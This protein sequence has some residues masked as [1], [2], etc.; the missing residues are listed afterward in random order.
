MSAVFLPHSFA[1]RGHLCGLVAFVLSVPVNLCQAENSPLY[2]KDRQ[3][4]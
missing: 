4:Q 3:T 2:M 1:A